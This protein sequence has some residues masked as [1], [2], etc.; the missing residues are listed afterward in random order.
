[1]RYIER[2]CEASNSVFSI[3]SDKFS[4][5]NGEIYHYCPAEAAEGILKNSTLRF[6]DRRMQTDHDEAVYPLILFQDSIIDIIPSDYFLDAKLKKRFIEECNKACSHRISDPFSEGFYI[7]QA[8][9]TTDEKGV[10]WRIFNSDYCMTFD[11]KELLSKLQ[12]VNKPFYKDQPQK[13]FYGRVMYSKE[14]QVD[15]MK[16]LLDEFLPLVLSDPVKCGITAR[17]LVDRILLLGSFFVND[18][19]QHECEYK[20]VL[21]LAKDSNDAT[22]FTVIE[23]KI[24]MMRRGTAKVPYF[25]VPFA[26]PAL[27]HIR[28]ENQDGLDYAL[29]EIH[30][31]AQY[32]FPHL[33]G[34]SSISIDEWVE[35]RK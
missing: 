30:K 12:L 21:N 3:I 10:L 1:M 26:S 25:D 4:K 28:V 24:Q 22:E 34:R 33:C 31:W 13:F 35:L 20:F 15:L 5:L 17:L 11:N 16:E 29:E 2:L 32:S 9:F 27:T 23:N 19:H 6:T 14:K 18:K 8:C 7:F